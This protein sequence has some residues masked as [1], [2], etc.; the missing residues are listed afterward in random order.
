[1]EG[2]SGV[3]GVAKGQIRLSDY[4][5]E[6]SLCSCFVKAPRNWLELSDFQRNWNVGYLRGERG[7]SG[8]P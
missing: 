8:E 4:T 2:S 6:V 3:H 5:T 1:M 7:V